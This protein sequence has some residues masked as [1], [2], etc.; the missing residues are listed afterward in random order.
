MELEFAGATPYCYANSLAMM[1]NSAAPAPSAIEVLT[2]SPF[3]AQWATGGLPYFDPPGWDPDLGLDRAAD[4]L[5]WTC[6]HTAGGDATAAMARLRAAARS[7]PVLVGPV[8]MGLLTHQPEAAGTADGTD[9]WVVVLDV[10]DDLVVFHDPEG[11]PF[12]TLP[13]DIFAAAWD[14]RAVEFAAPFTLRSEFRRVRDVDVLDAVR[15]SLPAARIWL[16]ADGPD[17]EPGGGAAEA[18]ERLAARVRAGLDAATRAHLTGFAVRV[19]T[20]RLSDAA[21][22]LGRAGASEAAEVAGRQARLL[23][24]AQY[25]LAVGDGDR[26]AT[27]LER[28]AGTYAE[29]RGALGGE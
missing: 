9:H 16:S 12:A 17:G 15:N 27:A 25:G 20:R 21:L 23:G 28:L 22:W 2:G 4:L 14:S 19:G 3:G 5:G 29:L 11:F 7:G 1:L 26:A 24:S 6:R 10:T 8:D 18:V 13:A